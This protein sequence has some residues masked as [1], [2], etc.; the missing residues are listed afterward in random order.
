MKAGASDEDD[1]V[2]SAPL[3]KKGKST[4]TVYLTR[5]RRVSMASVLGSSFFKP[6]L[7]RGA[8]KAQEEEE[9]TSSFERPEKR[10]AS[11]AR[12]SGPV[13]TPDSGHR[14]WEGSGRR[15]GSWTDPDQSLDSG[16]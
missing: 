5:L 12:I 9:E 10:A 7:S 1:P 3:S 8:D 15:L 14:H 13:R 4:S 2:F 16:Q 6:P 11:K